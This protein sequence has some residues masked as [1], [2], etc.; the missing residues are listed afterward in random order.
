M[1]NVKI[2]TGAEQPIN[3]DGA[4]V[5]AEVEE[6]DPVGIDANGDIIVADADSAV[7]VHAVGIAMAPSDDLANYTGHPDFVR[8][9]VESERVLVNRDRLAF[10]KY[11][12]ILENSDEDWAFTPG[13]PVYLAAGGGYTQTKPSAIGDVVQCLGV[14]TDDGEAMFLDIDYQYEVVA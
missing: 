2:A 14:A 8:S 1:T 7:A 5:A 6:G 4:I 11:G 9:V 10:G 3:R 12:F 13:E